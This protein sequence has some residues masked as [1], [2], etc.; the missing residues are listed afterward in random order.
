MQNKRS[1]FFKSF[2]SFVPFFQTDVWFQPLSSQGIV[3]GKDMILIEER[4]D[5]RYST[6]FSNFMNYWKLLN[7]KL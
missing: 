6:A 2:F 5:M 4:G 1:I 7:R 3:M